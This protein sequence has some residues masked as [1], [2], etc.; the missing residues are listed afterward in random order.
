[1]TE[2]QLYSYKGADRCREEGCLVVPGRCAGRERETHKSAGDGS[3]T[4][5]A[6][7]EG[8]SVSVKG[9]PKPQS[10]ALVPGAHWITYVVAV[11]LCKG[12]G[13]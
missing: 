11:G 9:P 12:G 10:L 13:R 5:N 7:V 3:V 6:T 4:V 8:P 1:M 2:N